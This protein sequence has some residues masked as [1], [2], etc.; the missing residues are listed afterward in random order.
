MQ[1]P[2]RTLSSVLDHRYSVLTRKRAHADHISGISIQMRH[3]D[4]IDTS[5]DYAAHRIKVGA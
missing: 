1:R 5:L 2:S 4:R 3:D